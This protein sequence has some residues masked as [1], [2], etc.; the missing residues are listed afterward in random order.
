M[1]STTGKLTLSQELPAY[2]QELLMRE[3]ALAL[4][5]KGIAEAAEEAQRKKEALAGLN[6]LRSFVPGES[7]RRHV[8]DR[9]QAEEQA[10]RLDA[11]LR[12]L[13]TTEMVL[14]TCVERSLENFLRLHDPEYVAGLAAYRFPHDWQ[15]LVE[16]FEQAKDALVGILSALVNVMENARP[17]ENMSAFAPDCRLLVEEA[18]I[19]GRKLDAE[20]G[21]INAVA[22]E[23]RRQ[24]GPDTITLPRQPETGWAQTVGALL[25][26]P[27]EECLRA[28]RNLVRECHD[29]LDG[30]GTAI[31]AESKLVNGV[32]VLEVPSYH[33]GVWKALREAS[34][35][36]IEA[37]DLQRVV[38]ETEQMLDLGTLDPWSPPAPEKK[39]VQPVA[40][41]APVPGG[42]EPL[43]AGTSPAVARRS[44]VAPS[45]SSSAQAPTRKEHKLSLRGRN[46]RRP[47][48]DGVSPETRDTPVPAVGSVALKSSEIAA[49]EEQ[50]ALLERRLEEMRVEL[51]TRETYV[52]ESE[53]R[54]LQKTQ[55]QVE[56]EAEL[57]QRED[58]LRTLLQRLDALDDTRPSGQSSST[59]LDEF[60]D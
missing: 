20:I 57:E 45:S 56:R 38:S 37:K 54:L 16:R 10:A 21:F 30:I 43:F 33:A 22:D 58:Q 18:A 23:Q 55:Q 8:A 40:A 17:K 15:R 11:G 24:Y 36:S 9:K 29:V 14:L 31:H 50:R 53:E 25:E 34:R 1:L 60:K 39:P 49:L 12:K 52:M 26:V 35:L 51:Q 41:V 46:S 44:D 2:L 47:E 19:A 48:M 5:R 3:A 13:D 32:K 4:A 28:T 42:A 27:A 59:K 6:A 7:R